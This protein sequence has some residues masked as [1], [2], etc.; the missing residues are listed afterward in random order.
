MYTGFPMDT[1]E[2][3]PNGCYKEITIEPSLGVDFTLSLENPRINTNVNGI[4][5]SV[6]TITARG[7]AGEASATLTV[8]FVKCGDDG[9][10]SPIKF[11]MTTTAYGSEHLRS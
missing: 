5:R 7:D 11:V 1:V 8:H 4:L 6:Y 3:I 9:K 2:I 10:N